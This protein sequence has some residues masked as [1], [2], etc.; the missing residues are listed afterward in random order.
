MKNAPDVE[1][2]GT[3]AKMLIMV[4]GNLK[5]RVSFRIVY[6]ILIEDIL[7]TSLVDSGWKES[8]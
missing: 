1:T 8:F 3:M 5:Y 7:C 6:R 2:R 4:M